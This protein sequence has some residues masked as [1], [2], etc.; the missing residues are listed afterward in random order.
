MNCGVRLRC[1]AEWDEL[2]SAVEESA[3]KLPDGAA[4]VGDPER[5]ERAAAMLRR[6]MSAAPGNKE[7]DE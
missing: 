5:L 4:A 2:L 3:G 6:R 1:V 7:V